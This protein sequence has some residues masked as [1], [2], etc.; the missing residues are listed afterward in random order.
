MLFGASVVRQ[1][2]TATA[3]RPAKFG[4]YTGHTLYPGVRDGGRDQ[5][6]L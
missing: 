4:R 2:F 3:G 6:R 1:W 5:K